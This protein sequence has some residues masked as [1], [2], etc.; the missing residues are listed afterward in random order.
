MTTLHFNSKYTNEELLNIM[1][2][3]AENVKFPT[4]REFKP[5]NELP[6][7]TTYIERFGSF[8]DAII[9]AGITIPEE[10]LRYFNREKLSNKDLLEKLKKEVLSIGRQLTAQEI[11]KNKNLPTDTVFYRR[12]GNLEN[13]YKLIGLHTLNNDILKDKLK[14]KYLE[15]QKLLDRTPTSRDLDEYSKK[16][17]CHSAS[18]Y[19]HHFGGIDRLQKECNVVP[20]NPARNKSEVD[21]VNDLKL[22]AKELGRTPTQT[23]LDSFD[24]ASSPASYRKKFGS[25]V[26]ALNKA[27]FES[28]KYKIYYTKTGVPCLSRMEHLFAQMLI[29]YNILFKKDVRYSDYIYNIERKIT[30]DFVVT[31][32]GENHFVEIFGIDGNDNYDRNKEYKINLCK[33]N[34]I[35]LI[36]LGFMDFWRKKQR[37]IYLDLI[38]KIN[39]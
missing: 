4:V 38:N 8:Q 20:T 6:S 26:K 33:E 36:Q 21:M 16:G 34:G 3:Y 37:D 35:N 2:E 14:K 18:T 5:S 9:K 29:K 27:G 19:A 39:F 31:I 25:F 17:F 24:F 28:N 22:I 11:K 15:L 13:T 30:C 1:R 7:S 32:S 10:K 23:D 12:F